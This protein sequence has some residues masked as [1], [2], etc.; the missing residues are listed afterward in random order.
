MLFKIIPAVVLA[1]LVSLSIQDIDI[2]V[3]HD[4]PVNAHGPI[5]RAFTSW[6]LETDEANSTLGI[7]NT[8]NVF[9]ANLISSLLAVTGGRPWIRVGGTSGDIGARF[10]PDEPAT[11]RHYPPS[12]FKSFNNIKDVDYMFQIPMTPNNI[13]D[14]VLFFRE[15]YKNIGPDRLW[16]VELGN[17]ENVWIVFS[18]GGADHQTYV[19]RFL[20]FEQ[21]IIDTGLL[22]NNTAFQAIDSQNDRGASDN[23]APTIF[24][25]GINANGNIKSVAMHYYQTSTSQTLQSQLMNHTAI[26]AKMLTYRPAIQY[27]KQNYPKIPFYLDEVGNGQ[28]GDFSFQQNFGEALWAVDMQLYAMV[29]DVSKVSFLLRAESGNSPWTAWP[30]GGATPN[31]KPTY[32][33]QQFVASFI[34]GGSAVVKVSLIYESEF[35]TAYGAYE[36]GKLKRIAVINLQGWNIGTSP[37]PSFN[38]KLHIPVGLTSNLYIQRF[39]SPN[40]ARGLVSDITWRGCQWTYASLGKVVTEVRNDAFYVLGNADRVATINLPASQAYIV[41]FYD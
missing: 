35:Y 4:V 29:Q 20:R 38:F 15:A 39:Q 41:N 10:K 5:D 37:R 28:L 31:V 8:P 30:V 19:N 25:M 16:G 21:A 36:N 6:S 23:I 18:G 7:G 2:T 9:N 22:Q 33:A 32:Y 1:T 24:P 34:G 14:S 26:K 12:F 40:G 27:M 11:Y 3:A 13:T 17:E